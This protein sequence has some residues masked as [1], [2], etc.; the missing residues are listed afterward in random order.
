MR[1]AIFIALG[2]LFALTG[3]QI[4]FA[5]SSS[6]VGERVMAKNLPAPLERKEFQQPAMLPQR[7]YD[8]RMP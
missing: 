5:A 8:H 1:Y 6:A 2:L 3:F 4:A 7:G